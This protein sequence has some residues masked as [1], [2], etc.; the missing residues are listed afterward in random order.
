MR[1]LDNTTS[2]FLS[3]LL[4]IINCA[5]HYIGKELT[6]SERIL[7]ANCISVGIMFTLIVVVA[8]FVKLFRKYTYRIINLKEYLLSLLI[9]YVLPLP[10]FWLM[11][12][13]AYYVATVALLLILSI[14]GWGNARIGNALFPFLNKKSAQ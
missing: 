3:W 8:F 13:H 11:S 5:M 6:I 14:C 1:F 10:L 4:I 2:W 7:L 12:A 9:A